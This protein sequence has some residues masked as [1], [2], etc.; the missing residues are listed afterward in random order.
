M[1]KKVTRVVGFVS[2]G[3]IK[4]GISR[5]R[6]ADFFRKRPLQVKN[7]QQPIYYFV[8]FILTLQKQCRKEVG[9]CINQ[10]RIYEAKQ[11]QQP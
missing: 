10:P 1:T 6:Y 2:E 3:Y 5:K 9:V 7:L 8:A 4:I 11:R